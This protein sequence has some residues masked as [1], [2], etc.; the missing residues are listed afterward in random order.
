MEMLVSI[1]LL[2][3]AS[4]SIIVLYG[5]L[6]SRNSN[7]ESV[8]EGALLVQSCVENINGMRKQVSNFFSTSTTTLGTSCNYLP[9]LH[10]SGT[11][12]TLSVSANVFTS[13]TPPCPASPVSCL[14][15]V[16]HAQNN[17]AQTSSDTTLFFINY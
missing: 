3:I 12:T 6:F 4:A 8:Q 14:K 10:N 16:I 7:T 5:G 17:G 1:L 11:G 15:F 13:V 2:G 9:T